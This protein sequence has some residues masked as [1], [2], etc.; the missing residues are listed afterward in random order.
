LPEFR[1]AKGDS[2]IDWGI[3]QTNGRLASPVDVARALAYLGS[4][5]AEFISGVNLSVDNGFAAR[6]RTGLTEGGPRHGDQGQ[7]AK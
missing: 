7:K 6:L 5:A 1:Q 3:K 4:D 2:F